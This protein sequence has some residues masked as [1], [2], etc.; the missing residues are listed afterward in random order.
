MAI[1][2]IPARTVRQSTPRLP[3][4][5]DGE[6]ATLDH[7]AHPGRPEAL[8]ESL[9]GVADHLGVGA[10]PN[11]RRT[12]QSEQRAE[13]TEIVARGHDA[14]QFLTAAGQFADDVEFAF[15]DDVDEVAHRALLE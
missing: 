13:L 2:R 5:V 15:A 9:R 4:L 10:G 3:G 11:G 6:L 1:R 14:Q 12:G 8:A 7:I